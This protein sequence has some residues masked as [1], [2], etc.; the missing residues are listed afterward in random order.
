[1]AVSLSGDA[2]DCDVFVVGAGLA[3]LAAAIGFAGRASRSSPAARPIGSARAARWPCSAARSISSKAS[4][5]GAPSSLSPRRCARCRIIDDTGSLF[6]PRPVEFRAGE[7]GLDAFGWNVENAA[8]AD[9]LAARPPR[10]PNLRRVESKASSF[11]FAPER[12][13]LG[14]ADGRRF[15]ARLV[16]GADGRGSS[17]R[18]AAGVERAN[19][20]S[21]PRAR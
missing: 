11:D 15:Q 12:A 10:A 8:L 2:E 6:S 21:I 17:A 3:G 19:A 7:I 5:S 18:K 4:T 20:R 16:V 13:R 1:M 14:L 9:A